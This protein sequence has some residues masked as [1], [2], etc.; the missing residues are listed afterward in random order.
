MLEVDDRYDAGIIR[1]VEGVRDEES[2]IRGGM[3]DE[4]CAAWVRQHVLAMGPGDVI[5]VE[6]RKGFTPYGAGS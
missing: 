1:I 4:E 3:T 5:E 2:Q 6:I